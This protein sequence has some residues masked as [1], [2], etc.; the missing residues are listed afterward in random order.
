MQRHLYHL[1][2]DENHVPATR[3]DGM[4]H[5]WAWSLLMYATVA[6]ALFL[7]IMALRHV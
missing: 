1:S 4:S 3:G 7:V 2:T 6:I 5:R